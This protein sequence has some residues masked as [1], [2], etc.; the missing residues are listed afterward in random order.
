MERVRWKSSKDPGRADGGPAAP[1]LGPKFTAGDCRRLKGGLRWSTTTDAR[2]RHA[3]IAHTHAAPRGKA[4]NAMEEA[5]WPPRQSQRSQ[6]HRGAGSSCAYPSHSLPACA[7]PPN[8][9]L[10]ARSCGHRWLTSAISRLGGR[11]WLVLQAVFDAHS[12][13]AAMHAISIMLEDRLLP[14][15]ASESVY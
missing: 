12:A 11:L 3:R 4:T 14:S 9:A 10:T 13:A 5:S 8:S 2:S 15:A 7:R 1:A 6:V